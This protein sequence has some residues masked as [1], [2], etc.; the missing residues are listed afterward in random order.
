MPQWTGKLVDNLHFAAAIHGIRGEKNEDEVDF[1]LWRL[2]LDKYRNA[3]WNEISGGF[4]MRFALAKV[5]VCNPR[6]LILDE[7]LANLDVNTQL[8]F[9]QDLRYLADSLA[10]PKTILLSSQHLYEVESITDNIIFIKEGAVIYNGNLEDF[11]K[12]KEENAFELGCNLSKN[13]LM[14]LL[15]EIS[16]TQIEMVGHNQYIINA[17][18]NIGSNEMIKVF[19]DNDITLKYF[20]DISKSTRRLF[21]KEK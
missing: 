13:E 12:D 2:G 15:E 1:I 14:D 20:R 3:T 17:S 9:L 19:I 5:L 8:L 6:F 7:P 10:H 11:G 18:K 4:K 21:K 16:Y